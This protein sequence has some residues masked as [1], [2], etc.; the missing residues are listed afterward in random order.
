M[1]FAMLLMDRPGTAEL[2]TQVRPAHR[3]YL[4]KLADKMAFSGPLTSE[5]GK[6]AVGSLLVMDF[7]SKAAAEAWLSEEPFTKAG[8]YEKPIIH[9][10]SNMWEQK[11]GFPPS[12]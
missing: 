4:A 10:F 11:V 1:I 9:A 6:T 8:V 12:A 2:R 5:D 3:D 7:P